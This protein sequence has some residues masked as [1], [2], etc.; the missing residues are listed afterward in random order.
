[1]QVFFSEMLNLSSSM[2][3]SVAQANRAYSE[4]LERVVEEGVRTGVYI[5][6]HPKRFTYMLLGACN[7][8]YRWYRPGGE[9]TPDM[10]AEEIIRIVESGCL[11]PQTETG[12]AVPLREVRALRKEVGQLRSAMGGNRKKG[13]EK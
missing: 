7:W 2:S 5:A 1:M 9:W 11:Q 10:I 6:L 13:A 8:M 12:E 4:V 3:R